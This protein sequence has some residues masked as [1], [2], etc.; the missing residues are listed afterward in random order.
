MWRGR[1]SLSKLSLV[2]LG[3]SLTIFSSLVAPACVPD[4]HSVLLSNPA[5]LQNE[6]VTA[7]FAEVQQNLSSLFINT[8]RD[9]LSFAVVSGSIILALTLA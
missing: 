8:T 3:V 6:A 9:G 7:A 4:V 5:V 2:S 1:R